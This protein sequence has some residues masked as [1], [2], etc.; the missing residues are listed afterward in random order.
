MGDKGLPSSR[1]NLSEPLRNVGKPL[2]VY[3]AITKYGMNHVPNAGHVEVVF[4]SLDRIK[5]VHPVFLAKLR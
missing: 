4:E 5:D 3:R 2:S 1:L